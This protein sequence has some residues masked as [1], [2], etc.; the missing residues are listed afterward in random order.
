MKCMIAYVLKDLRGN[1]KTWLSRRVSEAK[2]I[3]PRGI[4]EIEWEL[5]IPKAEYNDLKLKYIFD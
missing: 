1:A 5:N 2:N 4:G 3:N